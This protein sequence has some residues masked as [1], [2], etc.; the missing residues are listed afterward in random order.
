MRFEV[1]VNNEILKLNDGEDGK[2]LL[3]SKQEFL[4]RHKTSPL[5]ITATSG[6]VKCYAEIDLFLLSIGG[7][8]V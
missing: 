6:D 8:V 3:Q 4:E 7:K 2:V 1:L 5:I